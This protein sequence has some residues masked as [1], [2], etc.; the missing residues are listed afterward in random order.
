MSG[1]DH[2]AAPVADPLRLYRYRD[3]LYA[4]DL[5]TAAIVYLD[6]FTWL[7][8]NPSRREEICAS[9]KI[10]ERPADVMLTLF[11]ANGFVT[12]TDGLYRNTELAAEFLIAGSRLFMGPYY[13]SLQ[14]RPVTKN[15]IEVLRHDKPAKWGGFQGEQDWHKAMETESFARSF[16]A[17]MD[18]RG[19]YLGQALARR[20]D[21]RAHHHL[22]D[23]AGGSGVYA[24]E[25]TAA[26]P[27]LSATVLEK[28]PVDQLARRLI[29][30]QGC[31]SKVNVATGD[32]F[33][34]DW[35]RDCD[36]HL[37]SNVLHDW[38]D[39]KVR[40]LLGASSQH[41]PAGGMI[42]IHDMHLNEEKTGPLPVAEY[43]CLL[44]HSTE[45]RCYSIRE[46]TTW[47]TE[48]GFDRVQWE[49]TA[50]DRSFIS[51]RKR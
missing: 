16:T 2:R 44:M 32:M 13:A 9:L 29:K 4:V 47:L 3:G 27:H 8:K 31:C 38:D 7:G 37:F 30:E 20:L 18:C 10:A 34:S 23:I 15:F 1:N 24:C 42:V 41:L 5:L 19:R 11:V 17:A 36:M 39:S 12:E 49:P 25:I 50:A 26:H 40:W 35:P 33:G 14:E 51:A 45:G 46:L 22:L 43:S 28:P 48:A 6:F 21:C